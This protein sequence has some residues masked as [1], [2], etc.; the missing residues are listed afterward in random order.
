M[1]LAKLSTGHKIAIWTILL[2]A[3]DQL[4]KLLVHAHLEVGDHIQVFPWFNLCYVENPGFAFGMQLG[5]GGGSFD[6]GKIVL[7][8]FRLVMI[9][10][11]IY[12]I[13]YL[14]KKGSEVPKGVIVGAVLILA[15]AIGNMVDSMFYGLFIEAQGTGFLTGKVIDMIHLPL[16]KWE[17]CPSFLSFLVGG[18]GYFFGAV[19][20]VA[21]AYISCAVVYLAIFQYKFFK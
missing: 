17:S 18:D 7:S 20:N 11:L 2:V 3:L 14:L 6:W 12:G 8:L 16:F 15:G 21:D 19:F 4:V 10:A 1:G 13:R 5:S 9:G